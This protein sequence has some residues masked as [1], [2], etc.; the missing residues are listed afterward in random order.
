MRS[1]TRRLHFAFALLVLCSG[2]VPALGEDFFP[3]DPP[4]DRFGAD[5]L[6]DLRGLNERYAGEHGAV[7]AQGDRFLRGDGAPLRFWGVHLGD[8][9]RRPST[10]E[11]A[12]YAAR[13]LAKLGVNLVRLSSRRD[14]GLDDPAQMDPEAMQRLFWTFAALREQG[15]YALLSFHFPLKV[16]ARRAW[17]LEGYE[18]GQSTFG[19]LYFDPR[20]QEIY[21]Q[22]ARTLLGTVNP[23]TGRTLAADPALALVEIVNED[24][25]FFPTFSPKHVP[26]VQWQRMEKR[27]GGWLARRHGTLAAALA[28][29]EHAEGDDPSAGRADLAAAGE[30]SARGMAVASEGRRARLREQARFFTEMQHDF[31]ATTRR[32]LREE[33]GCRCLVA[34][35]NWKTADPALTDSLE[36]FSYTAGD[37]LDRH[38]YFEADH[39][40][41]GARWSVRVGQRFESRAAVRHPERLPIQYLHVE[42]KPLAISEIG[43]TQPNRYRAGYAFLAA[44][45]GALQGLDANITFALARG[46]DWWRWARGIEKFHAVTPAVLGSFP[47]AALLYRRG[48]V[49]EAEV[50][51]REQVDLE[52]AF[53]LTRPGGYA[54]PAIERLRARAGPPAAPTRRFDPL[55]FYVGRVVRRFSTPGGLEARDLAPYLDREAQSVVSATGELRWEWG[56]G[57]VRLDTPRAQGALGFLA[58]AGEQ[59]LTDVSF[60][61]GNPYAAVLAVSLDGSP[62]ARARR[63][64]VQA[65]SEERFHGARTAADGEILALGGPPLE[66]RRLDVAVR[67]PGRFRVTALDPHGYAQGAARHVESGSWLALDPEAIYHVLEREAL[68]DHVQADSSGEQPAEAAD[69][70]HGGA[71]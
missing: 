28:R 18:E 4:L 17:G 42:G 57:L 63:I 69:E 30:L 50:V 71:E 38:G 16:E 41:E 54:A 55:S 6:L 35:S 23:Y 37:Y 2:S 13:R 31:Y 60:R 5:A 59:S 36:R 70:H 7:R 64:L 20:M 40:G 47:A 51:V 9:G 3:W 24:S 58:E 15:I 32:F 52:E 49:A 56:R 26:E 8:F 61:V 66:V 12:R 22:R 39:E 19:L 46:D 53:T 14:F 27:F 25:L 33:L 21:R 68:P 45:Y 65:M 67:L 1:N 10:R 43:W 48:D 34:A 11:Q 29:F 44:G 62:L